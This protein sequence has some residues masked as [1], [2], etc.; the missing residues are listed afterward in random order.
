M[1]PTPVGSEKS[2]GF[3]RRMT[4]L[5]GELGADITLVLAFASLAAFDET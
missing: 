5:A 4:V 3:A 2:R 1:T